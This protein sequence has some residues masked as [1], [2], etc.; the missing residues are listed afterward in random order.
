MLLQH[1]CFAESDNFVPWQVGIGEGVRAMSFKIRFN[2]LAQDYSTANAAGLNIYLQRKIWN[3][4]G[5]SI[6]IYQEWNGFQR[7]VGKDDSGKLIKARYW[8]D[9]SSGFYSFGVFWE[10]ITGIQLGVDFG[11]VALNLGAS[12]E[13]TNKFNGSAVSFLPKIKI[14]LPRKSRHAASISIYGG[15]AMMGN[16]TGPMLGGSVNY[17]FRW[18]K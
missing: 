8:S 1:E 18:G 13:L 12:D 5:L 3:K 2:G 14:G 17:E 15:K 6:G 16:F 11:W 4:L 10:A 7:L 9:G